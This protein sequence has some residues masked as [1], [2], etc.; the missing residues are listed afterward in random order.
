MIIYSHREHREKRK[1]EKKM[2][3]FVER[4]SIDNYHEMMTGGYNY[5]VEHLEIEAESKEEAVEKAQKTGYYVNDG[6]VLSLEEVEAKRARAREEARKEE[7]R[8]QRAKERKA[9]REKAKAEAQG[10]TVEEYKHLK[11]RERKMKR[12]EA[13]VR[14]LEEALDR[15][16]EAL[17]EYTEY[18]KNN[19]IK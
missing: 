7:E 15:A 12:M 4:M 9:E 1:G 14:E 11:N 2:L 19:P 18:V 6:Y 10:L 13:N 16:R 5:S 8:K 17:N 3:Y